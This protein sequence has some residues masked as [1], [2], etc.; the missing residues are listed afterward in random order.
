MKTVI[1]C[2]ASYP[3][4]GSTLV[5]YVFNEQ[6][7]QVVFEDQQEL[8][9]LGMTMFSDVVFVNVNIDHL[10]AL[11]DQLLNCADG[12]EQNVAKQIAE[13]A[14]KDVLVQLGKVK[15]TLY[16]V[17]GNPDANG[18]QSDCGHYVIKRLIDEHGNPKNWALY[19][20]GMVI[21]NSGFR[22]DL[23]TKYNIDLKSRRGD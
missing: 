12:Q 3:N 9:E 5:A 17:E 10:P 2:R 6:L 7:I 16:G 14:N 1:R 19:V 20:N 13:A 11:Q 4:Q 8:F 22:Y 15:I 21:D 23:A 18:Y